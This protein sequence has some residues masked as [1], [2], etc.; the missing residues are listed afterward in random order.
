[1]ALGRVIAQ[2]RNRYQLHDGA[3][4][5]SAQ[6][7]RRFLKRSCDPSARPAVG[8]FVLFSS[9]SDPFIETVLPR[10]SVLSRAAAGERLMRQV[11]AT[12]IDYVLI[13]M[14]LDGDFNPR[15][16]E[17]YLLLISDNNVQP[18]IILSKKDLFTQE[19]IDE[20][21]MSLSAVVPPG[22][23][24]HTVNGKDPNSIRF[25]LE[26]LK[27]GTTAVLV[28]SSGAGKSTLVNTL[29]GFNRQGTGEVR[30]HD[31]RGRH[32]T[33][34]RALLQ[35]PSG[36]CLIDTPGMREIKLTG[37]ETFAESNFS[38]IELLAN[39]C[40]FTD[41]AH[42]TEPGCAVRTA[43]EIGSLDTARWQ[44]YQKLQKELEAAS[45]NLET[46]LKRKADTRTIH[47]SLNK[48]L[49]EKY[50]RR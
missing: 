22:T 47:K 23:P 31:S 9:G 30:E 21:L 38:D 46:Q 20:S 39:N 37:E 29:L 24:I 4:E 8:D 50:G 33:T 11:I 5:T 25:L 2:H 44:N 35:L 28:G 34:S 1:M 43:L 15:R 42:I 13:V 18:I 14:G 16:L 10:R 19:E 3:N 45:E 17:R 7:A 48:R 32:T 49:I 41:C 40:R 12:N 36:G 26:Y 6:P 27:T